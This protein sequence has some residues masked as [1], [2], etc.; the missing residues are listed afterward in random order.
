MRRLRSGTIAAL[1]V[2]LLAPAVGC[3]LDS[4]PT[5]TIATSSTIAPA[6]TQKPNRSAPPNPQAVCQQRLTLA[7]STPPATGAP[8]LEQNLLTGLMDRE[9]SRAFEE[10]SGAMPSNLVGF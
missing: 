5:P 3:S 7:L 8:E 10:L 2:W 4:Q 1:G 6:L 9:R